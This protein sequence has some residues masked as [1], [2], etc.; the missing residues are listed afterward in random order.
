[1]C[2]CVCMYVCMWVYMEIDMNMFAGVNSS[3]VC[4]YTN[5]QE[6]L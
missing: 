1:M 3:H 6:H 2:V 5:G 4:F